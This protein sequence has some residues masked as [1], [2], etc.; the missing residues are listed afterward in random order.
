MYKQG[1]CVMIGSDVNGGPEVGLVKSLLI[2]PEG[3]VCLVCD[4][5]S[6]TNFSSHYHAYKYICCV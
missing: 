1:S 3:D 6:S 2:N 5:L 4:I